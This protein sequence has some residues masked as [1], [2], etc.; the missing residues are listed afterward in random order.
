MH[1]LRVRVIALLSL[2][3]VFV[4]DNL[5]KE[6]LYIFTHSIE[7]DNYFTQQKQKVLRA[8]GINRFLEA[9]KYLKLSEVLQM[10]TLNFFQTKQHSIGFVIGKIYMRIL[11]ANTTLV[12]FGF[13]FSKNQYSH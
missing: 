11:N 7:I 6:T 4:L 9:I 8:D 2:E 13:F 1:Q 5:I 10:A 3:K 12:N